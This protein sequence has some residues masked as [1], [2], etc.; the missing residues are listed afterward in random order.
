MHIHAIRA[1]YGRPWQ[2]PET[3][4]NP[5]K[6]AYFAGSSLGNFTPEESVSFLHQVRQHIGA[7]GG[8]LIGIDNKKDCS[9][10]NKAYNDQQGVTARFNLNALSHINT[11]I[12]SRF[13]TENF[14]HLA[15]Y[16]EAK[17]RIEMHLKS[18]QQQTISIAEKLIKLEP[19]ETIHTENS[20]KYSSDEF[21]ALAQQASL[22]I[23][24]HWQDEEKLF[25]IYYLN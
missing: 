8:L 11:L 20:Y 1:D 4:N 25:S 18:L 6:L 7:Q 22:N 15:F 13:N 24:E 9:T 21:A 23:Q 16:N 3:I 12:N 2:L 17:G 14:Q 10:L 5:N 19:G